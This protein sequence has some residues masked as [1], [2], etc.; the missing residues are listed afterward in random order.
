MIPHTLAEIGRTLAIALAYLALGS[1][2]LIF[3]I[4]P[5]YASPIFPA[6]G[7]ALAI[8][9]I[10]GR[11]ALPGIWL[12]SACLNSGL[13]LSTHSLSGTTFAAASLIACGAVA[14]AWLGRLLIRRMEGERWHRLEYERDVIAFLLI[15]G[16]VACLV[17]ATTGIISLSALDILPAAA[18]SFAWWNWFVGDTLGVLTFAPLC[19]SVLLRRVPLWR[20]R[21]QQMALPMVLT[22]VCVGVAIYFTGRWEQQSQAD[23]LRTDA[24]ALQ[25]RIADRL[26]THQEALQAL[27]RLIEIDPDLSPEQFERYTLYTLRDNPDI[28]ALSF[29]AYVPDAR[30]TDFE[31][32]MARRLGLPEF[33][34]TER[35]PGGERVT[36][37]RREFHVPVSHIVP[38]AANLAAL[39]FDI[40]SEP[41]RRDAV[42]RA[43]QAGSSITVTAP[44]RLVQDTDG[45]RSVLLLAPAHHHRRADDS[46]A[47]LEQN[48][49]WVAWAVGVV[50]LLF[51]TLL[52]T[53]ILGMTGR[54]AISSARSKSRLPT[55]PQRTGSW[56]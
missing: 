7:L 56:P 41:L 4:A 23:R 37:A 45:E 16:P 12:G 47:Y 2:G 30:R 55:L 6:S 31:R 49:P 26:L 36:A 3:A 46:D 13:A 24:L 28:S 5:G 34:I 14:Q 19:L 43:M 8:T 44:I 25:D 51:A 38:R 22:L 50:G 29:N 52:Q 53:L 33:R 17:S 15:G 42:N 18:R 9:L 35:N 20:S 11:R 54:T 21:L 1:L 48:R 40:H 27:R 39:G 10:L 32:D